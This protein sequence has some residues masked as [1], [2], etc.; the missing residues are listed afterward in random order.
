MRLNLI[1]A[2]IFSIL[3]IC[4]N[5]Q[6]YCISN[7]APPSYINSTQFWKQNAWNIIFRIGI[8][9]IKKLN[10][11]K[12]FKLI[13][14]TSHVHVGFYKNRLM[15]QYD[16]SNSLFSKIEVVDKNRFNELVQVWG[17]N[18]L[19]NNGITKPGLYYNES[20]E[21][22]SPDGKIEVFHEFLEYL[23][24]EYGKRDIL[25]F[26][27]L[28]HASLDIIEEELSFAL[29]VNPKQVKDLIDNRRSID[30]AH[31]ESASFNIYPDNLIKPY[32]ERLKS[33]LSRFEIMTNQQDIINKNNNLT[34]QS[35]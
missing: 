4:I 1:K 8:D 18:K 24:V 30:I 9:K 22:K 27:W 15:L 6:L 26:A 19:K 32:I 7:L 16:G 31:L 29:K 11:I 35:S 17:L 13:G 12:F 34:R 14:E 20:V 25:I 28:G 5:Q 10:A 2:V 3:M 21:F 33:I 23:A